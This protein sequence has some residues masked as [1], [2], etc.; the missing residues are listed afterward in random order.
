[1]RARRTRAVALALLA[2]VALAGCSTT[3]GSTDGSL[4]FVAGDGSVVLL[5]SAERAPAPSLSGTTL[6]GARLDLASLRGKVVVL[7][8]WASWCSPCREEAGALDRAYQA[9]HGQGVDFVGV[10]A[11][12]KDS[13]ENA[14]AFV[15]RFEVPYPSLYDGDQS[16]V[17]ALSGTLP[18]DAIPSTLVLDRQGRIAARTLGAVDYSGLRGMIDP[19]LAEKA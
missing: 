10:V 5:P 15:R 13:V 8:Y 16:I 9:T 12:G 19:V 4:G 14:A 6:D 3:T 7:N 18:P 2:V 1:M 11:G 17:L